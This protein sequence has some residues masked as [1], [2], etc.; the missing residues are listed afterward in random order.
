V[1]LMCSHLRTA[2][3]QTSAGSCSNC[4]SLLKGKVESADLR[5][6]RLVW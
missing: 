1:Q 6:N 3:A 5:K 2:G 4:F